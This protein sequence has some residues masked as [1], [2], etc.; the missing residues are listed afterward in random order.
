MLRVQTKPQQTL[1]RYFRSIAAFVLLLAFPAVFILRGKDPRLL[2][3]K[4]QSL[5]LC[6]QRPALNFSVVWAL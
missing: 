4:L 2:A 6:Y 3:M 1:F 5:L